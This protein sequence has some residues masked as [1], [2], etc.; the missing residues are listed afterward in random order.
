M[1]RMSER[2]YEMWMILDEIR[3]LEERSR[4]RSMRNKR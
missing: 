2:E 1:E 3:G 4:Q